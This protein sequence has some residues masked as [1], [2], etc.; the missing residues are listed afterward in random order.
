MKLF[1]YLIVIRALDLITTHLCI[2]KYGVAVEGNPIARG[3]MMGNYEGFMILNII[4]S[5]A[6]IY[7]STKNVR[8]VNIA[9]WGF[10]FINLLVVAVNAYCCFL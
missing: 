6:I 7:V 9:L 10:L 5:M 1:M 4:L 3:L 2:S 8:L